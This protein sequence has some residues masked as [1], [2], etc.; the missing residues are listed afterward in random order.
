[1]KLLKW[2]TQSPT[3]ASSKANLFSAIRHYVGRREPD[4]PR[5]EWTFITLHVN[6]RQ[7]ESGNYIP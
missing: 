3:V 2:L 1:M 7:M 4:F 6:S 5:L